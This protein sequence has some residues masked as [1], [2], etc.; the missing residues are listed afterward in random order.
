MRHAHDGSI[1]AS[2][3]HDF[4]GLINESVPGVAA[5]VDD[6]VEGFEDP[7]GGAM[8]AGLIE[9]HDAMHTR[10][11]FACDLVERELHRLGI[12]GWQHQG[13]AGPAL[14]A[15]RAE[16]VRRFGPLIVRGARARTLPGPAIG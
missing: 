2:D 5:V 8:S 16:Q 3:G 15:D 11:D 6:I 7:I 13:G 9:Q 12:A 14:G 4:P 1:A 10:G